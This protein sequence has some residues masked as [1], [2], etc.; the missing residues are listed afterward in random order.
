ICSA[1]SVPGRDGRI[2]R[3]RTARDVA[4]CDIYGKIRRIAVAARDRCC[5]PIPMSIRHGTVARSKVEHARRLFFERGADPGPS[6]APHITRSW[7]RC[8][9][10]AMVPVVEPIARA[11]LWQR[12][13]QAA[14]LLACAQPEMEGLAEHVGD[15]GCVVILA[16]AGGLILDQVGAAEF[17]PKARR[18]ALMPGVEWSESN[19]GTNAIGT[20]LIERDALTVLGGEHY[21]AQNGE[22]GCAAAPI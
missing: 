2:F 11:D 7:K 3:V 18:I 5:G 14:N 1:M 13:E 20:A 19:R 15:L 21:L 6:L 17:L 12:R 16:D 22:I 10:S 8:V 9:A 4:A